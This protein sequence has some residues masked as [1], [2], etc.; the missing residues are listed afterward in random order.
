MKTYLHI[1]SRIFNTPLLIE[2]S[3]LDVISSKV[4]LRLIS[5]QEV[6]SGSI[7][8]TFKD[9]PSPPKI[10][11]I[12]IT[13]T[14]VSKN[15]T[16]DSG[17]LSYESIM[18]QINTLM[19]YGV[20]SIAFLE[21]FDKQL[22]K[23]NNP[24]IYKILFY[25]DSPGGEANGNFP[26]TDFIHSL[27]TKYGIQTVAFSDGMLTSGAYSIGAACQ[28]VL[29]T[30][31][32]TTGSV[33]AIMSLI[34]MTKADADEGV[35][36]TILRSLEQKATYNPHESLTSD[37]IETQK[38]KLDQ[39]SDLFL[40]NISR[41]RPQLSVEKLKELKG[42]SFFGQEAISL[43]LA[44][45]VVSSLDE[46]ITLET[47]PNSIGTPMPQTLEELNA[48]LA[49]AR[50]DIASLKAE[51]NDKV[52]VA[53]IEERQRSLAII[54]AGATFSMSTDQV[55]K[56]VEKGRS[57][58]DTRDLFADSAEVRGIITAI[59][60]IAITQQTPALQEKI[61][62]QIADKDNPLSFINFLDEV[63][64]SPTFKRG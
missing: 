50:L 49:Q 47:I 25:I 22:L 16:G 41:Y 30:N 64:T 45:K 57:A 17:S 29:I 32:T 27:P 28:K 31:S 33:A 38:N 26:L 20:N 2:P 54:N 24:G 14:L 55:I 60:T 7:V 3:K 46:V 51:L 58:E 12:K 62:Q 1:L 42:A 39:T 44:D 53:I 13:G 35:S 36:Y 4:G 37:V 21:D 34:D 19:E 15:G 8:G 11:I 40:A 59:N 18:G 43:F 10:G 6:D 23:K 61:N 9:L 63:T 48:N 5:G 56:M 52:K